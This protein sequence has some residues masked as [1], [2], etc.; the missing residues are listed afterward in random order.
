MPSGR[1]R[2]DSTLG[3]GYEQDDYYRSIHY[4]PVRIVK[5]RR[6]QRNPAHLS[7][8]EEAKTEEQEQTTRRELPWPAE[9]MSLGLMRELG[10]ALQEV[11]EARL[12]IFI[13]PKNWLRFRHGHRWSIRRADSSEE[14]D[15]F[16]TIQ[17]LLP[18]DKDDVLQNDLGKLAAAMNEQAENLTQQNVDLLLEK[19]DEAVKLTGNEVSID[20]TRPF[21]EWYLDIL[22]RSTFYSDSA[23][24]VTPPPILTGDLQFKAEV[25]RRFV[26]QSQDFKLRVR[27][28]MLSKSAEAVERERQRL[29]RYEGFEEVE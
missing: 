13:A 10:R 21:A 28:M 18:M 11:I 17:T 20:E 7:G 1:L 3:E 22:Q 23:G 24:E 2:R 25:E 15:Q 26:E 8:S 4:G 16:R 6:V 5:S 27:E 29:S 14:T 12:A 9:A 19:V